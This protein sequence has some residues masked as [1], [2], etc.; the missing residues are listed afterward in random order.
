[1]AMLEPLPT[2]DSGPP[3]AKGAGRVLVVDDD[4][5]L[6]ESLESLLKAQGFEVETSSTV[7]NATRAL[8]AAKFDVVVTDLALGAPGGLAF[9]E[10]VVRSHPGLP[11]VVLTGYGDARDAAL[12]LGA[13]RV[14][15]KPVAVQTLLEA[16]REVVGS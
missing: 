13:R 6:L 14:L 2:D 3:L 4:V 7:K 5:D 8:A 9:C 12:R 15:Q 16:L 10:R 1:M 11:I